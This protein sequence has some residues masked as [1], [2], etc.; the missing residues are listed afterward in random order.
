M[1]KERRTP[2]G[3]LKLAFV[4]TFPGGAGKWRG[5]YAEY[6][7]DADVLL[8]PDNDEAG[9]TGMKLIADELTSVASRERVLE[10]PGLSE[11][12]DLSNWLSIPGNDKKKLMELVETKAW[13]WTSEILASKVNKGLEQH[14]KGGWVEPLPL[15]KKSTAT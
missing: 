10:L 12:E 2:T 6:F 11:K 3:E 15:P 9:L 1:L 14:L 8:V 7:F 13:E 4:T 5:E